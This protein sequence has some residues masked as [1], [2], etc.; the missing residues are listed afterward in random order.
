[1]GGSRTRGARPSD[2]ILPAPF[3][4]F[5]SSLVSEEWEDYP[6]SSGIEAG[7]PS[8]EVEEEEGESGGEPEE[9]GEG[10][11]WEGLLGVGGWRD[12]YVSLG[13]SGEGGEGEGREGRGD[14]GLMGGGEQ[15]AR[16]EGDGREEVGGR[17]SGGRDEGE[18]LRSPG[19][20]G[21]EREMHSPSIAS[22][23][24][25]PVLER[26]TFISTVGAG[27]EGGPVVMERR[28]VG[29]ISLPG[30]VVLLMVLNL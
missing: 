19:V 6:H 20:E 4:P 3:V 11:E 24:G 5:P 2:I 17:S 14:E 30:G 27:I 25:S 23:P 16:R 29:T 18:G 13:E 10:E 1:M 7:D 9:E 21:E 8:S 28:Q 22:Y 26:G 12:G 15:R